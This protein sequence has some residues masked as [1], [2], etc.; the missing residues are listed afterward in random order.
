M[1]STVDAVLPPRHA[2][3]PILDRPLDR[4]ALIAAIDEARRQEGSRRLYAVPPP[5]PTWPRVFP[6]L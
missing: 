6:Q 1:V 3:A 5:Q 2:H 4:A